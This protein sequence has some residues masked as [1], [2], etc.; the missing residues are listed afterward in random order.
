[1][2]ID[3]PDTRKEHNDGLIPLINIV[4]L[5]LIFFMI[6]GRIEIQ[7]NDDIQIPLAAVSQSLPTDAIT[8]TITD[9]GLLL[10]DRNPVSLPELKSLLLSQSPADRPHRPRLLV[11]ADADLDYSRFRETLDRLQQQGWSSIDLLVRD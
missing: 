3:Q 2:R 11:R 9:E 4:F 7:E 5:L 10:L 1:M 6:I 8:I